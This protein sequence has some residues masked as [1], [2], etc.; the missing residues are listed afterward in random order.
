MKRVGHTVRS[1]FTQSFG[2]VMFLVKN[3]RSKSHV[4][5]S[6]MCM[7]DD[8]DEEEEEEHCSELGGVYS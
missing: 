4:R 6:R 8:D 5:V 7:V 3:S 2:M 1:R